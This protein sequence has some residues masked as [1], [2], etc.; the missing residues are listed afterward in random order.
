MININARRDVAGGR[1]VLG[2]G[3]AY[4]QRLLEVIRAAVPIRY[5][6]A[7]S[8]L[9]AVKGTLNIRLNQ[10]SI[11][12]T[13]SGGQ[14]S[15]IIPFEDKV[16]GAARVIR[17]YLNFLVGAVGPEPDGSDRPIRIRNAVANP[18]LDYV[19]IVRRSS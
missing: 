16:V 17:P 18:L 8:A 2:G 3:A 10:Y 13:R 6:D 19:F 1:I 15:F 11:D 4:A 12:K 5:C 9:D 14:V 7:K